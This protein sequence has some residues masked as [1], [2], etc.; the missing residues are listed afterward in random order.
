LLDEPCKGVDVATRQ[1]IY[2]LILTAVENGLGVIVVSSELEE[3]LGLADRCLVLSDGLVVD[4]FTRG[5]GSEERVLKS[6][7]SADRSLTSGGTGL[8][9]NHQS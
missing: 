2:R 4:E 9:S 5:N 8:S 1:E 6:I 7:A 3:L